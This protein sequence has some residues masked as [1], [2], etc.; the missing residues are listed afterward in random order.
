[1]SGDPQTT[2]T[3]VFCAACDRMVPEDVPNC[4]WHHCLHRRQTKAAK[5]LDLYEVLIFF[6]PEGFYPI[7]AVKGVSLVQQAREHAE[8]NPGTIRIEDKCGLI[9]W[10]L[11]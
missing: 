7:K 6:R 10:V 8:L 5:E 2:A 9:L 4:Q 11:Q 3:G 1:M